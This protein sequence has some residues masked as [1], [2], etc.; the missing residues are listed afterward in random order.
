MPTKLRMELDRLSICDF[1]STGSIVDLPVRPPL[2]LE[3]FA[4]PVASTSRVSTRMHS[5]IES[6][7]SFAMSPSHLATDDRGFGSH[8]C[9]HRTTSWHASCSFWIRQPFPERSG[10]ASASEAWVGHASNKLPQLPP[11]FLLALPEALRRLMRVP[12]DAS[13]IAL[14]TSALPPRSD[15]A[16]TMEGAL[17]ARLPPARA[18][19]HRHLCGGG[20]QPPFPTHLNTSMCR[21]RYVWECLNH[22]LL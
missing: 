1:P 9:L 11:F 2:A 3:G 14:V 21:M 6:C 4:S 18:P 17:H 20:A 12:D 10:C 15:G 8:L 16:R 13:A 22:A 7:T 5:H 19:Q